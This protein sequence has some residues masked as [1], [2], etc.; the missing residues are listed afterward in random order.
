[1]RRCSRHIL[2]FGGSCV[3]VDSSPQAL[4]S[5]VSLPLVFFHFCAAGVLFT[6]FVAEAFF[7]ILA[8]GAFFV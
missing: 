3:S 5:L 7:G 4:S 1:L 2:G 8:A 6:S